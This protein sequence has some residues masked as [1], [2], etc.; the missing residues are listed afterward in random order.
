VNAGG[1]SGQA[2]R[3]G[4]QRD[5]LAGV[6]VVGGGD[7]QGVGVLGRVRAGDPHRTVEGG[8]L[9][10]L[11]AGVGRVVLYPRRSAGARRLD[12]GAAA[13][14]GRRVRSAVAL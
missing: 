14:D 7:D 9:A 2:G 5:D 10:D 4:L 12:A 13:G 8:G 3:G 1:R 6:A 11:A